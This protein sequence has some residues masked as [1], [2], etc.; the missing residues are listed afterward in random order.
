MKSN[1]LFL[2]LSLTLLA[3]CA[4]HVDREIEYEKKQVKAD[5]HS[6]AALAEKTRKMLEK[7]PNL[8][9]E[10]KD[11]FVDLHTQIYADSMAISLEIK[12]LKMVLFRNLTSDQISR[13][14]S[15]KVANKI[16]KLTNKRLDIMI[17]G[18]DEARKILGVYTPEVFQNANFI[19][20]E[21]TR[22]N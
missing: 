3:S 13:V 16:R 2:F 8:T 15:D 22:D 7:T 12:K 9:Q 4:T 14:K 20:F 1:V 6:P 5:L 19:H 11:K 18:L 17:A 21:S 10:Q